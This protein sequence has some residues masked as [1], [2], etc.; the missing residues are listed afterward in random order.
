MCLVDD[1]IEKL[2]EISKAQFNCIDM[3]N[4]DAE[5]VTDKAI[6]RDHVLPQKL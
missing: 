5:E 6:E 4:P 2:N 3:V 1:V